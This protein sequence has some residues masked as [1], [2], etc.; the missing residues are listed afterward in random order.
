VKL[1]LFHPKIQ[2]ANL[3]PL[4][5]MVEDI[6]DQASDFTACNIALSTQILL[7]LEDINT[8]HG[9]SK[10]SSISGV[11]NVLILFQVETSATWS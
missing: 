1:N 11:A 6:N 3:Q 5:R 9:K 8:R 7:R 10:I 2:S 4:Q